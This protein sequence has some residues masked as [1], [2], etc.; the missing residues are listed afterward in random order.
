[1]SE[2]NDSEPLDSGSPPQDHHQYPDHHA[3]YGYED[4]DAHHMDGV[5]LP[6]QID[7]HNG[8]SADPSGVHYED[9]GG[10]G[11]GSG[12][13]EMMDGGDD[14]TMVGEKVSDPSL[15]GA[16]KTQ[17]MNQLM[18]S[19]QDEVYVFHAVSP[20]KVQAVLLLLGGREA[21]LAG[22]GPQDN[23]VG[24]FP[25]RSNL[26]QRLASLIRFREKRKERCFDKKIRY[27]VRKEVALRMRRKKGQFASKDDT[28][29]EGVSASSGL[30]P[31]QSSSQD[32]GHEATACHQC[33]TSA[34][35]TPMMRRGPA[36][37]RT[38]CNACGLKWSNKGRSDESSNSYG[39]LITSFGTSPDLSK[40][41]T[42]E[43]QNPNPIGQSGASNSSK[44]KN[45]RAPVAS[46]G[47]T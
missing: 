29:E 22:C 1:M 5:H 26:P 11:G 37:P 40:A 39:H 12:V 24:G 16:L 7:G 43:I 21:P 2:A 46:T 15:A 17:D 3:M 32:D 10:G 8:D 14:K 20:E 13:D 23:K 36:G 41:S 44:R 30:D 42:V 33:G 9:G 25:R 19:F 34:K 28:S 4:G 6:I 38:L 31:A 27:T 35:S 47:N 18:L 45:S